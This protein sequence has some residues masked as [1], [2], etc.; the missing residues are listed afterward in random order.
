[1]WS[2]LSTND[3]RLLLGLGTASRAEKIVI[4]WPPTGGED[5]NTTTLGP[6]PSG[7]DLLVMEGVRPLTLGDPLLTSAP[8]RS[9]QLVGPDL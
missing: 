1:M 9:V 2:Y 7:E 3:P 4:H 5:P 6:I 8:N